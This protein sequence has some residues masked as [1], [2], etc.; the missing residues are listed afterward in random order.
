MINQYELI[1]ESR[2][3]SCPLTTQ[4]LRNY[5]KAGLCHGAINTNNGIEARGVLP[6]YPS[7]YG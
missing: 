2:R 3:L 5:I 4:T 1:E 6:V 7:S